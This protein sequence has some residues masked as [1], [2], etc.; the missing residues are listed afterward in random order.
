[1]G[2]WS[3]HL[4]VRGFEPH[5]GHASSLVGNEPKFVF[6]PS[7]HTATL[8]GL[9]LEFEGST[10]RYPLLL[11]VHLTRTRPSSAAASSAAAAASSAVAPA[12]AGNPAAPA[13]LLGDN[14]RPA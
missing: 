4:L 13:F 5:A 11:V 10:P 14:L 1:M 2:R 3:L 6:L 8:Y 9:L 12:S 7:R